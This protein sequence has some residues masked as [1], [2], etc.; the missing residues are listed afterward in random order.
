MLKGDSKLKQNSNKS[1]NINVLVTV[2]I[3]EGEKKL[4]W[5]S[6]SLVFFI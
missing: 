6:L 2:K 1:E 5:L 4:W 3:T